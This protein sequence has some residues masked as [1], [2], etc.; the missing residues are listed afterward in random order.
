MQGMVSQLDDYSAYI[1]PVNLQEFNESLEQQFG[2]VGMEVGL[3]PKTNQLT[4]MSPLVGSPAYEAGIR[5]WRQNSADRRARAP[6]EC[7]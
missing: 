6:R 3:D 7:R 5:S 1:P 4:V 2:G